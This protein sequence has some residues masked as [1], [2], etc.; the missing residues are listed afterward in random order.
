MFTSLVLMAL[1]T[2]SFTGPLVD[3]AMSHRRTDPALAS[4]QTRS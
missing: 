2:T 1:L 3:Y 4:A